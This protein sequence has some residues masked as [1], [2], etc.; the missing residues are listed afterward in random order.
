[1]PKLSAEDQLQFLGQVNEAI[2]AMP[3]SKD[4]KAALLYA[5]NR[6][7]VFGA[8]R[9]NR[10][11]ALA[12]VFATVPLEV[13][14]VINERFADELLNRKASPA[15]TDARYVAICSNVM[16]SVNQRVSSTTHDGARAAFAVMML[17]RASNGAPAGLSDMLVNM[18]ADA[19]A[20]Q[21]AKTTWLPAALASGEAKS[22]DQILGASQAGEEPNRSTVAAVVPSEEKTVLTDLAENSDFA[23]GIFDK[24]TGLVAGALRRESEATATLDRLDNTGLD[25]M[26]AGDY[27]GVNAPR[28]AILGKTIIDPRTGKEIPNPHYSE[29]RGD[30]QRYTGQ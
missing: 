7:A 1:M 22:Y 12:E 10:T 15:I 4:Q 9:E 29:K 5:A 6:A 24:K 14:S 25:S 26:G 19:S 20:R 8:T 11:A 27:F 13:L 16:A 23:G 28:E 18:I 2:G 30:P 17:V 21:E 3:G